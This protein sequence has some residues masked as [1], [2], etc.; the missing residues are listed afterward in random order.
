MG[1]RAAA[2]RRSGV[3]LLRAGTHREPGRR[4]NI[5]SVKSSSRH[6]GNHPR[7]AKP[8][9]H[10]R[11]SPAPPASGTAPYANTNAAKGCA[12]AS[13]TG[14]RPNTT[15][16]IGCAQASDTTRLPNT[17]AAIDCAKASGAG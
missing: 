13:D 2:H 10:S 14:R 6:D 8:T 11:S 7:R 3:P 5:G 4:P 12:K 15:A 9:R 1:Y 16:A 17:T